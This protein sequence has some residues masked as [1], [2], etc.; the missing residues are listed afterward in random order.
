[1]A[2]ASVCSLS[3]YCAGALHAGRL[4]M[5]LL[6]PPLG[7]YWG[8]MMGG[9]LNK[10]NVPPHDSAQLRV[11]EFLR[12]GAHTW[13]EIQA[14]TEFNNDYLGQVLGEL[15]GQRKVRTGQRDDVRVYWLA[16]ARD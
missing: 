3:L 12:D 7:L 11:L 1:L 8:C 6:Y 5:L 14:A 4:N 16:N 13:D 9:M 2:D 10:V 15:F